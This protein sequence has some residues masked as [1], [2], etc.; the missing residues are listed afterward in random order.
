MDFRL[1]VFVS[2][3]HHLNFTKASKELY[4]S[5]PAIS[6]NIKELEK[7]YGVQ[8]FERM[9]GKIALTIAG[10]AFLAYAKSILEGYRALRL[11]MNLLTGNIGG[12]LH[13][14]ASTT[15]AQY[16]L[17]EILARF[18]FHF[19]NIRFLMLTGN[20]EQVEQALVEHRIDVGLVEGNS[21]HAGFSYSHFAKDELVMVTN[22][23]NKIKGK[24]SLKE[25]SVLPLVLRE[26][27]SGT[28]EVIENRLAEQGWKLSE[29]NVLLQLGS[30][31]G[32]K[33]F[34]E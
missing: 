9:G 8:L 28:L 20:S 13:V 1:S 6:K 31:E 7:E 18:I 12:T 4:I 27:G 23:H 22:A 14:G 32:I 15:I 25:L 3:A 5:Q 19:P 33:S 34:L 29:M 30:T 2:V 10:T 16:L 26:S 11:E 24:I 21:R 17:P